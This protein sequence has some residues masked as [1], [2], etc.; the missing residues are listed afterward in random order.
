MIPVKKGEDNFLHKK[1][2]HSGF[3]SPAGDYVENPINMNEL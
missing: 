1:Q 3:P 2:K